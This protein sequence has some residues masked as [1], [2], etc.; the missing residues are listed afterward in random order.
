MYL[1][2]RCGGIG[3]SPRNVASLYYGFYHG[4]YHEKLPVMPYIALLMARMNTDFSLRTRF[5]LRFVGIKAV[6]QGL[7][8]RAGQTSFAAISGRVL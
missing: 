2:L 7:W 4:L 6:I 1:L 3:D 5:H 8:L